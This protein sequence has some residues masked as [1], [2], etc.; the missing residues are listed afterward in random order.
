M[1]SWHVTCY[2]WNGEVATMKTV[3]YAAHIYSHGCQHYSRGSG[4]HLA[5]R[6]TW[7]VYID[8][9]PPILTFTPHSHCAATLTFTPTALTFTPT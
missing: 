1:V 9:H 7:V 3:H 2:L 5:A 6:L 8:F 4:S